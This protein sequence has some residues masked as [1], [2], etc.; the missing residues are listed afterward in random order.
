MHP[1]ANTIPHASS[2]TTAVRMAVA[3]LELMPSIPTLASTDVSAANSADKS[4]YTIHIRNLLL[5][6][7]F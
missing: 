5:F 7:I 4:A 1:V 6:G 2:S 3:R